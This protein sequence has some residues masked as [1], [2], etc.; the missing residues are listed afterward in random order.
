[1]WMDA[2]TYQKIPETIVLRELK[3]SVTE[4]GFR[5]KSMTVITTLLDEREFSKEDVAQLY[6][7]RWNVELDIR[8][9]KSN[10]NLDHVRC[11][12]PEMVRREL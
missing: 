4:P 11:K 3:F 12:S 10:L 6:G 9:I 2:E 7:F 5:T 1:M 8:S